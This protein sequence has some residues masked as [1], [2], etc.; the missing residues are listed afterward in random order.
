VKPQDYAQ[1]A[2]V[3]STATQARILSE[4]Q[5]DLLALRKMPVR[6]KVAIRSHELWLMEAYEVLA[7]RPDW[8]EITIGPLKE[9]EKQRHLLDTR[10]PAEREGRRLLLRLRKYEFSSG[11]SHNWGCA[12]RVKWYKDNLPSYCDCGFG[13]LREEIE[14][15]QGLR[16][17]DDTERKGDE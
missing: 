2:E 12:S 14:S 7:R 3:L 8:Q 16:G 5:A 10:T 1:F 6:D 9:L 4:I 17:S 13:A 11:Y 15:L